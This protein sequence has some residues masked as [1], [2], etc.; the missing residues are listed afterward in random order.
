MSI[1]VQR[2]HKCAQR[3]SPPLFS[4]NS[5]WG[6]Q[7]GEVLETHCK[8]P[9][10][11]Q[12]NACLTSD[13]LGTSSTSDFH[14]VPLH[15]TVSSNISAQCWRRSTHSRLTSLSVKVPA[16]SLRHSLLST[17][18]RCFRVA[19]ST[20]SIRSNCIT[21]VC[22][23]HHCRD[24]VLMSRSSSQVFHWLNVCA[25]LLLYCHH[26]ISPAVFST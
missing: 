21:L 15:S 7:A 24:C 4:F 3:A 23:G 11:M 13:K 5:A 8:Q 26:Y 2:R 16:C 14:V 1:E 20:R 6:C 25:P 12:Y 22:V 10:F 9:A 18:S 19:A 17:S